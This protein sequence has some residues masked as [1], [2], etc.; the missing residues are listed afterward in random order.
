MVSEREEIGAA[1]L[2]PA[3]LLHEHGPRI[4]G[5]LA[6]WC[7]VFHGYTYSRREVDRISKHSCHYTEPK[8]PW[9]TRAH[10]PT[11]IKLGP[12]LKLVTTVKLVL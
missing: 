11:A 9:S 2:L 10:I 8:P 7:A 5:Q 4:T 1:D 12:L 6:V 3:A